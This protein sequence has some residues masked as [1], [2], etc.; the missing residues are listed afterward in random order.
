MKQFIIKAKEWAGSFTIERQVG[1][2]K[3]LKKIN[4]RVFDNECY[5]EYTKLAR[6]LEAIQS[7]ISAFRKASE[8]GKPAT[9][10]SDEDIKEMSSTSLEQI[11]L[12]CP[13]ILDDD[14]KGINQVDL[15][16]ILQYV[17]SIAGGAEIERTE[18]EKKSPSLSAT[19][20]SESSET[21]SQAS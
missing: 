15:K 6:K 3:V 5:L 14:F 17:A 12:L 1:Q 18:E 9:E 21:E 19:E 4:I 20:P 8:E 13:D 11:K 2:K 10:L 7:K 16:A